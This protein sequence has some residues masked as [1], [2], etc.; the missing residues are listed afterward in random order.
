MKV[1]ISAR[2]I[3]GEVELR[4]GQYFD[5]ALAIQG[6]RGSVP[7]FKATVHMDTPPGEGCVWLKGWSENEGI[8]AA[9]E[10]AGVVKLTGKTYSAEM[11]LC[12]EARVLVPVE[13]LQ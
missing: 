4:A 10:A 3:A 1:Q 5:G 2:Y 7:E 9:L 11:D 8:P 13:L 12:F 6:F